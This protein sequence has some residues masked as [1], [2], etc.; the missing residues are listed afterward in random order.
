MCGE[1]M[2][3]VGGGKTIIRIHYMGKNDKRNS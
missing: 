3:G 2:E 1:D